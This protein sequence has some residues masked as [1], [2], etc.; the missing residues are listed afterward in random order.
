MLIDFSLHAPFLRRSNGG[1]DGSSAP[2]ICHKA[3]SMQR[4]NACRSGAENG[5]RTAAACSSIVQKLLFLPLYL[6]I[7]RKSCQKVAFLCS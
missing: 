4:A 2:P 3:R 5:P 1:F 7:C 6:E